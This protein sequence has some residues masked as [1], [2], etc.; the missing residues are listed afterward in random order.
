MEP[1]AA[2]PLPASDGA[3]VAFRSKITAPLNPGGPPTPSL[4][5]SA[6]ARLSCQAIIEGF[7][8]ARKLNQMS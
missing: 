1:D 8:L 4:F 5:D 7:D 2:I 6:S 3:G